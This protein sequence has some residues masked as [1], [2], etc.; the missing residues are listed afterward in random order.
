MTVLTP[1]QFQLLKM[2]PEDSGQTRIV[3]SGLDHN[4]LVK[5]RAT[6]E[7]MYNLTCVI[8]DFKKSAN[9]TAE[10]NTNN[11]DSNGNGDGTDPVKAVLLASLE[12]E[13]EHML[14]L[15]EGVKER[16][17]EKE[18]ERRAAVYRQY[19]QNVRALTDCMR[20]QSRKSNEKWKEMLE[21]LAVASRFRDGE[22]TEEDMQ[23]CRDAQAQLQQKQSES[24]GAKLAEVG[25][26]EQ[27]K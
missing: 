17:R 21:F 5:M 14:E 12:S 19:A 20:E 4:T 16:Q 23:R 3:V 27:G 11:E 8:D 7:R 22:E 13:R 2:E 9:E 10:D 25:L 18:E 6:A 1:P 26:C 15:L 24:E